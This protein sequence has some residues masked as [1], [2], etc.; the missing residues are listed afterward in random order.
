L[1]S[2]PRPAPSWHI[3]SVF[4]RP[5]PWGSSAQDKRPTHQPFGDAID[6][7]ASVE[8]YADRYCG[9]EADERLFTR[10][11][12]QDRNI[13]V[14]F[15]VDMSGSTDGWINGLERET[16]IQAWHLGIHPYCI[17]HRRRGSCRTCMDR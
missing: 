15:M 4:S 16:L 3:I 14:M 10:N 5:Q 9:L 11:R 12:K 2:A 8:A 13:A 17:T 7:H 6:L 1:S